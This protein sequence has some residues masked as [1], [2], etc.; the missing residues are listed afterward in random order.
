MYHWPS[1]RSL[2]GPRSTLWPFCPRNGGRTATPS[3]GNG[4]DA[5]DHGTE[6]ERRGLEE[7]APREALAGFSLLGGCLAGVLRQRRPVA[8]VGLAPLR[9][10]GDVPPAQLAGR[11][12]RPDEAEDDRDPEPDR[13]DPE[14]V[15]DQADEDDHD[16]DGKADRADGR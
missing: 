5:A 14:G 15:D 16:A 2:T 13:R 11:L 9:L 6:A 4:H 10:D 7:L 1:A 3:D 12:P 8:G